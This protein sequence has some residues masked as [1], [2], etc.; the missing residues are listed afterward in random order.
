MSIR[1]EELIQYLLGEADNALSDRIRAALAG[2]AIVAERLQ[3]LR[4]ALG[5]L[6]SLKGSI[7]PPGDLVSRTLLRID[8]EQPSDSGEPQFNDLSGLNEPERVANESVRL[9]PALGDMPQSA[10]RVRQRAY[11]SVMVTVSIVALSCLM[12]PMVLEARAHSRRLTCAEHLQELGQSLAII[13]QGDREHRFPTIP[14]VGPK[15]FAGAY[16]L[17]LQ[18]ADLLPAPEI[19]RCA[20]LPWP[21][22]G[23]QAALAIPTSLEFEQAKPAQQQS[24]R[25]TLGG[26]YAYNLGIVE[27]GQVVGPR[28]EG[29]SHFAILSDAPIIEADRETV[30]AHDGRGT[31]ILYEDGHVSFLSR[32][33]YSTS[34]ANH[35]GRALRDGG[36]TAGI[37]LQVRQ[38]S[39]SDHPFRNIDGENAA[40]LT[41]DDAVL[42]PSPTPPLRRNRWMRSD[43]HP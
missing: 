24:W 29:R 41:P 38:S 15:A 37:G 27:Y 32:S 30:L 28:C 4:A 25:N 12:L 43:E 20:S 7:E 42:G 34:P 31:N 14:V 1:D 18:D 16:S 9:Q 2:D 19:L 26:H 21:S 39:A 22:E 5:L 6:D 40:G 8:A 11:D 36:A 33:F 10:W 3:Q 13:V 23:R 17:F 35:G